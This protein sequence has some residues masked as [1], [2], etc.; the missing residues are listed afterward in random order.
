MNQDYM[1]TKPILPL[2][3]SMSLPM[4]LSM[5]VNSLYNIVDSFFVA[6]ISENAMNALSLVFPIQNLITAIAVGFGVGMNAV[7]AFYLGT[8][9]HKKA[10]DSM[11]QGL[12]LSAIHGLILMIVCVVFIPNFLKFFTND[13]VVLKDGILY[14]RIAF[15]FSFVIQVGIAFE[16]IYQSLGR[17]ALTMKI[18]IIGCVTNIILDPIMIYGIGPVPEMGVKGAAYAT[19]IGQVVSAILLFVFH[20]KLNREFEHDTKY[21][22]PD[23][24]IIK[25]IYAIGLPAIIAQAL[26]SIMVY[27][28]NLILKFSPSA[29]TAYGLFYK[30]QQFVLFLAFGLRDA[31]TPIIAFSYGMHSKKRIKDGIRYGLLYTIVLMV[32]GVAITEIF[33]GEFAALFNAGASREYFIGAMRIISISFIFA[34]INVAYQGIYQALDGGMESLVISMLRQLIIILPLAGIFSFFVRG[35]H[36]GVS[37]IWWAFPITEVTACIVGYLFL[38]RINKNKV[39]SLN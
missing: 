29:Q 19:V 20:M 15:S 7:I 11:A 16:K 18:M 35:G 27:V 21:M 26:M 14:G 3:L 12:L 1:K 24:G 36:I 9:D 17:M 39:E 38:K 32:I 5:L 23:G 10:E 8:E 28:M 6:R 4:V 13:P 25:E 33:P 22:K 37:L 31:I 30:V 2:V 34:G